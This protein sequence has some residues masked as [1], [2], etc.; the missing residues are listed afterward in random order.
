MDGAA[1][2]AECELGEDVAKGVYKT[3]L[4]KDLPLT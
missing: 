2:L 4:E 3:A 1:I